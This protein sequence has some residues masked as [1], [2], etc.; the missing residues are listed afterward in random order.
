MSCVNTIT[1]LVEEI[2]GVEDVAVNLIGKSTTAT[3]VRKEL[4][5]NILSVIEDAGFEAEVISVD[6]IAGTELGREIGPRTVD[7]RIDGMF[8]PYVYMP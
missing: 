5:D 8:C 7:L 4:A 3:I 6:P 2:P 1:S